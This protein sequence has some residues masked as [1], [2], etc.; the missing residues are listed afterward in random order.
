MV[1]DGLVGELLDILINGYL[2]VQGEVVVVVDKY[3]VWII[4]IIILFE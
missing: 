3:G 1:L 2:I 4:D